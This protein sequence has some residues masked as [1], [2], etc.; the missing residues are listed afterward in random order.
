MLIGQ[1]TATGP[2]AALVS[3][4][5]TSEVVA[6][7]EV[8]IT[9]PTTVPIAGLAVDD[10]I[11]VLSPV[12]ATYRVTGV[13]VSDATVSAEVLRLFQSVE[14]LDATVT[15]NVIVRRDLL[16]VQS[17]S[18]LPARGLA[19]TTP[20]L[21]LSGSNYG[22][23]NKLTLDASPTDQY[24][25]RRGD[26]VTQSDVKIGEVL[27]VADTVLTV[28]MNGSE[29]SPVSTVKVWSRGGYA[30]LA[31]R[32]ELTRLTDRV[33]KL[34]TQNLIRVFKTYAKSGS[35]AA[36]YVA[37]TVEAKSIVTE[38]LAAYDAY[39]AH[40]TR[41]LERLLDYFRGEKLTLPLQYLLELDF[42]ELSALTT[43]AL[44]NQGSLEDLMQEITAQF[45]GGN[46]QIEWYTNGTVA[47]DYIQRGRDDQVR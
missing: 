11:V 37:L 28:M 8:T 7:T 19:V 32:D 4:D 13:G 12:P 16:R 46:E 44:S 20:G 39:D 41:E 43:R 25:I 27:R 26:V 38:V 33:E 47:N 31:L 14:T 9:V 45:R 10:I 40:N 42:I 2:I 35:N 5:A 34:T 21:G 29:V 1:I 17:V 24:A 22:S 15:C 30:F 6:T 3:I 18:V 36:Q 23:M